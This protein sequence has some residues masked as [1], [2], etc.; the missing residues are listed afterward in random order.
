MNRPHLM[1]TLKTSLGAALFAA[2]LTTASAQPT[3]LNYQG[4]LTDNNGQPL[5]SSGTN[6]L[7]F[8]I[9]T[10]ASGGT[11]LWGPFLADGVI[12]TGHT[13]KTIVSNGRFNVI[14]GPT[15]TASRSIATI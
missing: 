10:A 4:R 13:A 15:D 7:A 3:Y 1:K 2:L 6:N 8:N 5:P 9:Y 12:G 14:L 11:A